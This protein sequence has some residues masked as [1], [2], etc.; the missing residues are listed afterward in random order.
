M[1]CTVYWVSEKHG[2]RV[3]IMPR[4]RGGEWLDS[5]I[6]SLSNQGV[7]V[8][9]SLLTKEEAIEL[10]LSDEFDLCTQNGIDFVSFPINDREVPPLDQYLKGFIESLN[11]KL[12]RGKSVVIHC[13]AGI[14]RSAIIAACLL[15]SP[16]RSVDEVVSAI[17][18]SRGFPVPDTDEQ[19]QWVRE[20]ATWS[21]KDN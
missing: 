10:E 5:D 3:G 7:Q 1:F 4:P 17:S 2:A 12:T 6:K 15:M 19:L 16:D 9:V 18:Q 14:G 20:F 13:R 21:K 8:V 11:T